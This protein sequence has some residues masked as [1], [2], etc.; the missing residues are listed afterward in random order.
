VITWWDGD[1]NAHR[2]RIVAR[3]DWVRADGVPP[4]VSGAVTAQFQTCLVADG[5][6]DVILDAV[7]A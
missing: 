3:R 4:P 6:R 1:G 7:T 2:L 5:S